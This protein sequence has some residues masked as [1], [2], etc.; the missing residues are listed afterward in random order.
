MSPDRPEKVKESLAKQS[1]AHTLLSDS[2]MEAAK[3]FGIA[4]KLDVATV[5]RYKG[6]GLDLAEA[7]GRDHG[8]LPVPA[9]FVI[10]GEG[11]IQFTYVNPDYRIRIH[12]EVLLAAATAAAG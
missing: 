7:S 6:F 4:F 5:E 2:T 8:L 10:D 11:R 12:P 1:F 3:A 9:V